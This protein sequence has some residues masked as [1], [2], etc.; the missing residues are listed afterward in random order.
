MPITDTAQERE[1]THDTSNHKH[2]TH[3][4]NVAKWKITIQAQQILEPIS[5]I[6]SWSV[7]PCHHGMARPQ[8]ADRGAASNTDGSCEYIEYAVADC[9]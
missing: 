5:S 6:I 1:T 9:R 7:L 3:E 8:A 2:T 4:N